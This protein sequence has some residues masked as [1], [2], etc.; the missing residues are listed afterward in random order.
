MNKN[1]CFN[2]TPASNRDK[3]HFCADSKLLI[4]CLGLLSLKIL[5]MVRGGK[6]CYGT[7]LGEPLHKAVHHHHYHCL[8]LAAS[9]CSCCNIRKSS[10][11]ISFSFCDSKLIQVIKTSESFVY[12]ENSYIS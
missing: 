5:A 11:S 2:I 6:K 12:K 4:M 10:N 7:F 1:F 9:W 8:S 3:T